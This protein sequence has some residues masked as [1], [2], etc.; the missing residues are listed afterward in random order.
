MAIYRGKILT[1][2]GVGTNQK[3]KILISSPENKEYYNFNSKN[4]FLMFIG[5]S[6]NVCIAPSPD[7]AYLRAE[8]DSSLAVPPSMLTYHSMSGFRCS[9]LTA[10]GDNALTWCGNELIIVSSP[11]NMTS[12]DS[13]QAGLPEYIYSFCPYGVKRLE[14]PHNR[15]ATNAFHKNDVIKLD[16]FGVIQS[17]SDLKGTWNTPRTIVQDGTYYKIIS[18]GMTSVSMSNTSLITIGDR[19]RIQH[20]AHSPYAYDNQFAYYYKPHMQHRYWSEEELDVI[21]G[22]GSGYIALLGGYGQSGVGLGLGGY[23][24]IRTPFGGG[25]LGAS[26]VD[27]DCVSHKDAAMTH[28][29]TELVYFQGRIYCVAAHKVG[30]TY[31]DVVCAEGFKTLIREGCSDTPLGH[32]DGE[33]DRYM[34]LSPYIGEKNIFGLN[35]KCPIK[36]KDRLL[37]L[38][39]NGIMLEVIEGKV[40]QVAD[41]KSQLSTQTVFASGIYGGGLEDG[42][43]P[44]AYKCYGAALGDTIHVF[45]NYYISGIVESGNVKA[46]MLWATAS[47]DLSFTYQALPSSGIIPPS[48]M[49]KVDYLNKISPF[50]FSGYNNFSKVENVV[51]GIGQPSGVE[52]CRPSGWMQSSGISTHWNGSGTFVNCDY[53][54][55]PDQWDVPMYYGHIDQYL[56]PT[57][58]IEPSGFTTDLKP[59]GVASSGYYWNGVCNY[60]VFG[61]PDQEENKLHLFFTEDLLNNNRKSSE[62][63]NDINDI[64]VP[65]QTLH[66]TLNGDTNV[67][68]YKNQFCSKRLSW[69]EPM[70]LLEPSIVLPSGGPHSPYPYEDRDNGVVYQ[71]FI[72]YDYPFFRTIDIDVQYS[73][74]NCL[75]W[76]NATAHS[77][78]S[79]S[80]TG[81]QTGSMI[82]DPSGIIGSGYMFAWNYYADG[83]NDTNIQHN[84][85]QLRIRAREDD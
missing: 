74:D 1:A 51:N 67:M 57:F 84:W 78:L 6:G 76:N 60:H 72:V 85:V 32:Y 65:D 40:I 23:Y 56:S 29:Q 54:L 27:F 33:V 83:L 73:I 58:T 11:P 24:S 28:I 13:A 15:D 79:C 35:Y 52:I 31:P 42:V 36:Y 4:P 75:T 48:G 45:L 61:Y 68:T 8:V 3:E 46:G 22:N 63:S 37:L 34:A 50:K 69:V 71:P 49:T 81:L 25:P 62:I 43:A 39:N 16:T 66:Y 30:V 70:D 64:Y 2:L 21:G 38:Q 47:D 53:S 55:S 20:T 17:C 59:S 7:H 10:L 80:K 18:H 26:H 12:S 82:V 5:P 41:I 14:Q 19:V 44:T 9:A 77:A